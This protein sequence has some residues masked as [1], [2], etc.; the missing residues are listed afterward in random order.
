[1]LALLG[2]SFD[3]V[4]LGHL[5]NANALFDDLSFDALRFIPCGN[6]A[7]GKEFS[8][9]EEHRLAMLELGITGLSNANRIE[10]DLREI[11]SSAI[12]YTVDTCRSIREE[13]GV[14]QSISLV[15]GQ[16]VLG[17]LHRWD[18]WQ[19][20]LEWVNIIVIFRPEN[21]HT[22]YKALDEFPDGSTSGLLLLQHLLASE[23][24]D[25]DVSKLL[26][27]RYINADDQVLRSYA[28]GRVVCRRVGDIAI[29]SSEIR[30]AL[31]NFW[32]NSC[33]K[34]V[35]SED[36]R[37]MGGQSALSWPRVILDGLSDTVRQYIFDNELY[38]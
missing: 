3:P 26:L 20:L 38:R 7:L 15:V 30:V 28:S 18:R 16:D 17:Q 19:S 37:K 27:N 35:F 23:R 14:E 25:S 4:H 9:T 33:S 21:R 36:G 8:V 10:I 6:H 2:G 13:L 22:Q 11:Q 12:S 24:A 31:K 32:V 1:M 34:S 29:S 5:N